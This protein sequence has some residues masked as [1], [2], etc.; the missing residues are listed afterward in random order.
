MGG[1]RADLRAKIERTGAPNGLVPLVE[2][3]PGPDRKGPPLCAA[4][5]G[6]PARITSRGVQEIH[7][8]ADPRTE[9][10]LVRVTFTPEGARAFETLT[11]ES[12]GRMLAVVALG[13]VQARPAIDGA[14][15]DGQ[16]TF[17]TRTGDTTRPVAI[18]RA[19]RIAE[20]SKLPPV[21]PLVIEAVQH[22]EPAN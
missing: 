8:D 5:L 9:E 7:L 2:C 15:R 22:G 4:W 13:E 11:R 20:A 1:S 6:S 19:R 21:P 12:A 17:S 18:Q 3:I 16:W 10:P 14:S